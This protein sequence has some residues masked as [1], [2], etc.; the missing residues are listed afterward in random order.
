MLDFDL[1][2]FTGMSVI[3]CY[4]ALYVY[5]AIKG[6]VNFLIEPDASPL[7]N[8]SNDNEDEFKLIV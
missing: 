3:G 1:I 5:D 4:L 6:I 8:P 2:S 7:D